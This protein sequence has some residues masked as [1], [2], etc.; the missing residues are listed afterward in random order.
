[1]MKTI[2]I[3][4]QIILLLSMI[5]EMVTIY[6]RDFVTKNLKNYATANLYARIS[7]ITF[8]LF[9]IILLLTHVNFLFGKDIVDMLLLNSSLILNCIGITIILKKN[10]KNNIV[11]KKDILLIG[12]GNLLNL[13]DAIYLLTCQ[14]FNSGVAWLGCISF[15]ALLLL[16]ENIS[17]NKRR[18]EV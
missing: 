12:I 14:C 15:F 8:L 4:I 13:I 7:K 16:Y 18:V 2:E 1:M 17:V 11:E 10:S 9:T 5:V 3:I 6:K